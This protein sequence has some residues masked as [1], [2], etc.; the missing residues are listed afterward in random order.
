MHNLLWKVRKIYLTSIKLQLFYKKR[1]DAG[2]SKILLEHLVLCKKLCL[3]QSM[4]DSV[5]IPN[6]V[7]Y[8]TLYY[9]SITVLLARGK[10]A[11]FQWNCA[12]SHTFM[13]L[14]TVKYNHL[15]TEKSIQYNSIR[16]S[17]HYAVV[18][19]YTILQQFGIRPT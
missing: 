19:A 17:N 7:L 5:S 6:I 16:Y 11:V 3:L 10:S 2:R 9:S 18:I 15:R 1:R 13:R 4:P 8:H 12:D 14:D